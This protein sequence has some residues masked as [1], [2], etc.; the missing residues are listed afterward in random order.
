MQSTG[1]EEA[2]REPEETGRW[3]SR[4]GLLWSP[5]H[6]ETLRW[7]PPPTGLTPGPTHYALARI[8][9]IIST[10][11]LFLTEEVIQMVM[12]MTNLHGRRT[13]QDWKDVDET[14][15][16]ATI[17]LLLLS[18]VFRS[19]SES[20]QSLWDEE[21]GRPIFRATMSR[22]QFSRILANL[23]FDDKL[24]RRRRRGD[25]FA[26][27][28]AL[29]DKW[30]ERLPMLFNPGWDVC[31]DEQLVA[32]KGRCSFR[33]YMPMKPA[34][35]GLKIRTLCDVATSYAWR[36]QPYTGKAAGAAAE[37]GQGKRVVLDMVEGLQGHTVT[38]DNLFSSSSLAEELLKRKVA[39]VST[40][41]KCKPELPPA[42]LETRGRAVT[43]SGFAFTRT[44][45][46]VSYVPKRGKLVLLLS[47]KHREPELSTGAKAKP[48]VILDYNRCKGAVDNLDKVVGTY[49]SRRK[50]RRWP[51]AIFNHILDI[52]AWNSLVL[53]TAVQPEWNKQRPDRRRLFLVKL[54]KALV[55]PHMSR[56]CAIPR[57]PVAAL[58]VESCR[59][60]PATEEEAQPVPEGVSRKVWEL[61]NAMH[62]DEVAVIIKEEKTSLPSLVPL[63]SAI[64]HSSLTTGT[65]PTSFKTAA[66]TPIL[67]KT[68]A[69]PSNFNNFRPIS[70][71]PFISKIL[72]K[73]VASQ[74]HSHLTHNNLYEQ[75]QSGFRP[76]HSTETALL[77]ITNDLLVAADSGLLT[78]LI[79][80]DL[81]AAF[82]TICHTTLLTRLSSIETPQ[83][84][85]LIWPKDFPPWSKSC[86]STFSES[87][88]EAETH[89]RGSDAIRQI[90]KE[91]GA[92]HPETLSSTKLRKQIS[93]LSTVLNLKDHEMDVLANFLGHDIRVHRQYYRLPEGTLELAKIA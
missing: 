92:K 28:R 17:E 39:L 35:Y 5:S 68:G 45:S 66:I 27:I 82:D 2:E 46:A 40:I 44:Q 24:N 56:R 48:V 76:L 21:T 52:S 91:C 50:S 25:K 15:I 9:S 87:K 23:R 72:E 84:S 19:R 81:S 20:L 38:C 10:M 70:N 43:S 86:V 36:M 18:G 37:V 88:P 47:T 11:D 1:S 65:V 63:I 8:T 33:Q 71:L 57:T 13:V 61:V 32:F 60:P 74:L 26:P 73:T 62:Q 41:R 75:F 89:L 83:K 51:M 93:T 31:V 58:M 29:W 12:G 53:W 64:I 79:L 49:S 80:L 14:D 34:K 55:T 59:P 3:R 42:L 54:G 67:K 16:R 6:E 30:T 85:I 4:S 90:A 78:I 77:K 7:I 69:D 22:G